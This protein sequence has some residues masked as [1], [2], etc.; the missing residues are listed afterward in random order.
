MVQLAGTIAFLWRWMYLTTIF[1][2]RAG[3]PDFSGYTFPKL[4][5]CTKFIKIYQMVIKYAE[6][7]LNTQNDREIYQLF[8]F[9]GPRKL[10]FMEYTIW[11]SWL[12]YCC[13][14]ETYKAGLFQI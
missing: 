14:L 9:H 2:L 3:L 5:K 10:G 1:K 7:P 13:S 6:W 8:P 4:E 11:Q 12:R